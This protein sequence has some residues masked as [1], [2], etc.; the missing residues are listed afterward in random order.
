MDA[1]IKIAFK[2]IAWLKVDENLLGQNGRL[3]DST[4][5]TISILCKQIENYFQQNHIKVTV[6]HKIIE[7]KE[8]E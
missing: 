6:T 5:Q 1:I 4:N 7:G 3:I 8:N 2:K